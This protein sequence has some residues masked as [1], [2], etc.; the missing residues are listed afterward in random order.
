MGQRKRR[1][2]AAALVCTVLWIVS[3][4][5]GGW[6]EDVIWE[7]DLDSSVVWE[8]EVIESTTAVPAGGVFT[9]S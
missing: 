2:V 7:D 9:P 4:S 8:D 6:D 3:A 5:A 1:R